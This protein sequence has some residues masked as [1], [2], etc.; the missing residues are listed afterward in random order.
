MRRKRN[1]PSARKRKQEGEKARVIQCAVSRLRE[2]EEEEK[3]Q[4]AAAI[5]V[6]ASLRRQ[7]A[8]N[9][10]AWLREEEE[11]RLLEKERQE[12]G[13]AIDIQ[14]VVRRHLARNRVTAVREE[15]MERRVRKEAAA[16]IRRRE[17]AA[18]TI[19]QWYMD[20]CQ[21]RRGRATVAL[22]RITERRV[23][24]HTSDHQTARGTQCV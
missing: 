2:E 16:T 15:Q 7:L 4:D 23:T 6:Q 13:A 5:T 18:T 20:R 12:V 14:T 24:P 9:R 3:R 10:M 21:Q 19:R 1:R 17:A 8:K 22:Q 11:R